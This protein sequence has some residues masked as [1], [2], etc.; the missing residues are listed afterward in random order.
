VARRR[1]RLTTDPPLEALWETIGRCGHPP[2]DQARAI[3]FVAIILTF[4]PW[5]LI[6][7][8]LTIAW[9]GN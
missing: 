6:P 2:R 4:I 3:A 7:L 9:L 1:I 8:G 5:V